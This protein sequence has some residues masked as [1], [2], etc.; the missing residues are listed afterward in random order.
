M[1]S[2]LDCLTLITEVAVNTT[3][4]GYVRTVDVLL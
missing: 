4:A 3:L 1:L 2:H